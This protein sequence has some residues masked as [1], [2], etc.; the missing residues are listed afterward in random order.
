ME[1]SFLYDVTC[2]VSISTQQISN[3]IEVSGVRKL[4]GKGSII[5]GK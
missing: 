3:T 4:Y 5:Q 1:I 2:G